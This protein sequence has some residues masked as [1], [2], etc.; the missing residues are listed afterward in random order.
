MET[1]F[2][3]VLNQLYHLDYQDFIT[4]NN[5]KPKIFE[6]LKRSFP[7]ECNLIIDEIKAVR[8]KGSN[9]ALIDVEIWKN[10]I[11]TLI[12]IMEAKKETYEYNLDLAKKVSEINPLENENKALTQRIV[13]IQNEQFI[14]LDKQAKVIS[15]KNTDIIKL[16]KSIKEKENELAIQKSKIRIYNGTFWSIII[17][18]PSLLFIIGYY[19]GINVGANRYDAEKFGMRDSIISLQHQNLTFKKELLRPIKKQ[20]P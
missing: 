19:L 6:L 13:D 3:S 5:L 15:E 4:L 17:G 7:E 2:D 16:N 12:G 10:G 11:Y 14:E 18:I 8:L 20:K 1:T 9:G